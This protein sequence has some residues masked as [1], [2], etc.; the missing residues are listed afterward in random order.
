HR[1]RGCAR[2]L[3]DRPQ[4]NRVQRGL[5]LRR[6]NQYTI[7]HAAQGD[8]RRDNLACGG[9]QAPGRLLPPLG[10][11]DCRAYCTAGPEGRR[12]Y[13]GGGPGGNRQSTRGQAWDTRGARNPH[14]AADGP[15]LPRGRT[16]F[17]A[18]GVFGCQ[19]PA[20][21]LPRRNRDHHPRMPCGQGV[22]REPDLLPRGKADDPLVTDRNA[23]LVAAATGW[24]ERPQPPLRGARA[25]RARERRPRRAELAQRT[26]PPHRTRD[27]RPQRAPAHHR[28]DRRPTQN[29]QGILR[30]R[31]HRVPGCAVG[32]SRGRHTPT[33]VP[34]PAVPQN[35]HLGQQIWGARHLSRSEPP[36]RHEGWPLHGIYRFGH[37]RAP[38]GAGST[39]RRIPLERHRAR[40]AKRVPRAGPSLEKRERAPRPTRRPTEPGA[41][42]RRGVIGQAVHP[43]PG[44]ARHDEPIHVVLG[45]ARGICALQQPDQEVEG[46][47]RKR[48]PFRVLSRRFRPGHR[49]Q[50]WPDGPRAGHRDHH[51]GVVQ[52]RLYS[53]LHKGLPALREAGLPLW[54]RPPIAHQGAAGCRPTPLKR[55]DRMAQGNTRGRPPPPP[56]ARH[57]RAPEEA[58]CP[59]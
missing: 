7:T 8:D 52:D 57:Q 53:M 59:L 24:R 47:H 41:R 51:Q 49:A 45:D 48:H 40:R 21:Q 14:T 15:Q 1:R 44:A 50:Q 29:P 46:P 36:P 33:R 39:D 16:R 35:P 19:G 3:Q 54:P 13:D 42:A 20:H 23:G 30:H 38:A 12:R 32:V 17:D 37:P 18:V 31:P 9:G 34:F 22:L 4:H 26:R 25:W 55:G 11:H 27:G 6:G 56:G 58:P 28:P 5:C 2:G 43:T 10:E